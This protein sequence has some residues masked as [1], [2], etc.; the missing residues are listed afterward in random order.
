MIDIAIVGA[1]PSGIFCALKILEEFKNHNFSDF[2]LDIF[3]KSQALRTLLP[4][5]NG[6]CNLTNQTADLRD[7]C[8]NYP[9]GEKFLYSIFSRFSNFDTID[10][11]NSIGLKTYVQDDLRVFPVS[12]SAVDVKNKLL[13]KLNSYKNFKLVFKEIKSKKDLE[14]YDYIVVSAG[15]KKVQGLLDSLNQSYIPFKKALCGLKVENNIYPKGVS[16]Q[17]LDGDFVFSQYGITG[18]LAFKI[19][20]LMADKPFPYEI[21]INLFNYHNLIDLIN[22]NP[23]KAFG[24]LVSKFIPKSLAKAIVKNYDTNACEISKKEIIETS[25]LILNIIDV[26]NNGE[27]VNY[28]GVELDLLDK[29]CKSKIHKN[30]WFCGEILNIDGFCGGF[31]LQNCWSTGYIVG[32]D[33]AKTV[34]GEI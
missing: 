24:N 16:V 4:T 21:K 27:I 11:F 32:S 23:K 6:R 13:N 19:S 5:G 9:R 31:N 15:S 2:N 28:G 18:P 12:N 26:D 30:L 1:G 20:S 8:S 17:S 10:Y 34:L 33:V 14:K 25:R 7:F 3:D 22:Q 29:N